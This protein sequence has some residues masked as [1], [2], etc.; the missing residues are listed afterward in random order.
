MKLKRTVLQLALLA[1]AAVST[2]GVSPAPTC[3]WCRT[4]DQFNAYMYEVQHPPSV[5]SA[6]WRTLLSLI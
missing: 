3:G 1:A 5:L 4:P 6:I 2:Q